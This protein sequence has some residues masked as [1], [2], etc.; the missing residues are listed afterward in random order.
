MR[1]CSWA[2]RPR[3]RPPCRRNS[4]P[5]LRRRGR[6]ACRTSSSRAVNLSSPRLAP[7][8]FPAAKSFEDRERA[9]HGEVASL[10]IEGLR[11]VRH[12]VAVQHAREYMQFQVLHAR[13]RA[14]IGIEY[15][16]RRLMVRVAPDDADGPLEILELPDVVEHRRAVAGDARVVAQAL[17]PEDRVGPAV[18]QAHHRGAPVPQRL[19]AKPGEHI[20]EIGF[21]QLDFREPR[22]RALLRTIVVARERP[23]DRAP[24]QIGRRREKALRGELVDDRAHVRVHTVH[25]GSDHDRRNLCAGAG[26]G[27]IAIELAP[28]ARTNPDVLALHIASSPSRRNGAHRTPARAACPTR[29]WQDAFSTGISQGGL[30]RAARPTFGAF[31]QGGV[32]TIACF[33]K[34]STPLGVDL[35]ALIAAMQAFVDQ[36]VM[37]VW[38]TPAK[39]VKSKGYVKGAWAV[40]FLDNADQPGALAYHDLTPD[41]M[42]QSKVFV[43]T[44]LDN[45]DLVSVSAS[46][47]LV[48]MPT[49]L[50]GHGYQ[51]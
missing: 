5:P 50:P 36:Y 30:M 31:N 41:G 3:P 9:R 28:L 8:G 24:E 20:G 7:P 43:K 33:N 27:Q 11:V 47:E 17:R 26:R 42:P 39:L 21:T 40:V 14:A 12:H 16:D 34:A 38:G 2:L 1:S 6:R 45:H 10:A 29:M 46:H 22:L 49:R 25:G 44:T 23:R 51:H 19:L 15:F 37:P 48:E 13:G 35:D 18:A 32:P 4:P